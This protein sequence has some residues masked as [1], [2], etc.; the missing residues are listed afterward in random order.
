MALPELLFL[1]PPLPLVRVSSRKW[2]CS[3]VAN[4]PN[5]N[6]RALAVRIFNIFNDLIRKKMHATHDEILL[7][8]KYFIQYHLFELL[9][10]LIT[11]YSCC[12]GWHR[13][14][15]GYRSLL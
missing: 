14:R 4:S 6:Q 3:R 2:R 13:P 7:W 1:P 15:C 9:D 12:R 8:C 11:A 5:E 10:N